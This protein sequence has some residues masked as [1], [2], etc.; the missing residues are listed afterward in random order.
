M[1]LGVVLTVISWWFVIYVVNSMLTVNREFMVVPFCTLHY[2]CNMGI[3]TSQKM[4]AHQIEVPLLEG[5]S[6]VIQIASS[7][8]E[9]VSGNFNSKSMILILNPQHDKNKFLVF[10]KYSVFQHYCQHWS[11]CVHKC[12]WKHGLQIQKNHCIVIGK[13]LQNPM[14]LYLSLYLS[15]LN[16]QLSKAN[17]KVFPSC[18]NFVVISFFFLFQP[19]FSYTFFLAGLH[20][21]MLHVEFI[22]CLQ[23]LYFYTGIYAKISLQVLKHQSLPLATHYLPHWLACGHVTCLVPLLSP[24]FVFLHWHLCQVFI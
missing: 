2:Y 3:T 16:L 5:L 8:M 6:K 21:A 17:F 14:T 18:S 19:S 11:F 13:A 4:Q 24:K 10:R 15:T 7:K 22:S 20:V 23:S 12:C 9:T 1:S